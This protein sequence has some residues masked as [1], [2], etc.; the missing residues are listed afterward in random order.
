MTIDQLFELDRK[1]QV[2][3]FICMFLSAFTL[4]I[5]GILL[6]LKPP[7][8]FEAPSIGNLS[9]PGCSVVL[10]NV[11]LLRADYVGLTSDSGA[12]PNIDAF[13]RNS[14]IFSNVT[15]PAGETFVSNTSVLTMTD[16]FLNGIK[17]AWI[18]RYKRLEQDEK[19]EILQK[20]IKERS[21]AEILSE[22]GYQTININQGGRAGAEAFLERGFAIHE[23]YSSNVLF[24]DL[25][26]I[27]IQKLEEM[28]NPGFFL[29]RPT[30]LHNHQ[31][32]HPISDTFDEIEGI[33]IRN[34]KYDSPA[35]EEKKGLHLKR[36]RK[37]EP[38]IGRQQEHKIYR[39]QV[40]Y[41]DKQLQRI[42]RF[43]INRGLE[44]TIVV[45]YSNH[46]TGLGDNEKFEHGTSYQSNV[47]VPV[48]I[49]HPYMSES[50]VVDKLVSL[51]DLMP[52]IYGML[53][54]KMPFLLDKQ[55]LFSEIL[56]NKFDREVFFGKNNWD[57][58]VRRDNWKLIIRNGR[59]RSLFNL[60]KDPG[61]ENNLFEENRDIAE[62]L[63]AEL[64]N[65]KL[66]L[67]N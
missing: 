54:F 44:N 22:N 64:L 30:F 63:E 17:P 40:A 46:G 35:G 20:V 26:D 4:L 51:M 41:G 6:T 27:S 34:Y 21:I 36:N 45:L 42:F 52:T 13:F 57:E 29:F 11:E 32:R 28:D 47:H 49:R 67:K 12:T 56:E 25:V 5:G 62:R 31:Y 53:K 37:V 55:D 60:E 16:P 14:I 48:L 50:I 23:Q 65:H 61:E 43:L 59:F 9:C 19:N 2:V 66:Q 10:L 3:V 7:K 1:T 8:E 15:A 24:E 39:N 18:D 33:R 38:S 58:Y